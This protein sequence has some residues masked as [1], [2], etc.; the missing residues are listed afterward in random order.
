M[1]LESRKKE[2]VIISNDPYITD[3]VYSI[4]DSKIRISINSKCNSDFKLAT[5]DIKYKLI[6][7]NLRGLGSQT[8][9]IC[10]I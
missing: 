8:N 1:T 9:P 4:C 5:G 10:K 2:E 7:I 6:T 3:S